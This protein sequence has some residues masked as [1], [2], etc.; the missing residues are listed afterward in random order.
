MWFIQLSNKIN[1]LYSFVLSQ[2]L[3]CFLA[4][5]QILLLPDYRLVGS[6]V[7]LLLFLL[8]LLLSSFL[9]LFFFVGLP[10]VP[11]IYNYKR[12]ERSFFLKNLFE[13]YYTC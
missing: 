5:L 10:K 2:I 12:F 6:F 13:N 8:L 7:L 3:H 4:D 9:F 11:V 1:I